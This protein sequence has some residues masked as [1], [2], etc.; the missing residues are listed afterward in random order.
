M[1]IDL[2]SNMYALCVA[3]YMENGKKITEVCV[4]RE[5]EDC[6]IGA[7]LVESVEKESG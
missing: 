5:V 2:V 7:W 4:A 1:A 6:L 3:K